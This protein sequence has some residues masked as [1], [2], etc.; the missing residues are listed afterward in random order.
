MVILPTDTQFQMKNTCILF[1]LLFL[2]QVVNG[3]KVPLKAITEKLK[4]GKFLTASDFGFKEYA[5]VQNGDTINFYTYQKKTTIPTSIY[6]YL[7]GSNAE[8]IY[9]YHKEND[10]SYWFNSL[11]SFDFSYLPENYLFVI[12]AKPGFGFI[13]NGNSNSIP[14][15]YWDMTSLQDRVMR[16]SA[17]LEYVI[18]NILKKP[19]NVVV[20]GYSEGF[21]VGAKLAT[22]NKRITHLGIGGGGANSDFYDFILANLK[23]SYI[24]KTSIDSTVQDNQQIISDFK[25]VMSNPN[26]IDFKYGYTYKRWASFA[27][28][29]INSLI[30]LKIPIFQIHGALDESTPV[31][32]AYAVPLEFARLKKDNL[33]FTIY[34]NSD[35]SLIERTVDKKEIEHWDEMMNSFFDWVKSNTKK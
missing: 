35:H 4:S 2:G 24:A 8:N 30:Q 34:S 1:L 31:E 16:A 11:T 27:E 10:S 5:F 22:V 26:S 7:P 9:T 13:N 33:K 28:P 3:Q 15:K 32:S 21:Y 18:K 17:S 12:V 20:F 29:S 23:A 19:E 6:L 14:Q 25:E